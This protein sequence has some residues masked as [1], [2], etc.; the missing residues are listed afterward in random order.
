[1]NS[2]KHN[3]IPELS[4]H[5]DPKSPI[6]DKVHKIFMNSLDVY[7]KIV[8]APS[9]LLQCCHMNQVLEG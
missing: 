5:D 7:C 9:Q 3:D 2:D 6:D 4:S 1:M 8:I